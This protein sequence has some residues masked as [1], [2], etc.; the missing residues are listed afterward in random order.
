MGRLQRKCPFCRKPLVSTDEE[1]IELM[2]KRIEAND[3]V[4]MCYIGTKKYH[5]GDY[6]AAFEYWTKAVA[7]GDVRAHFELSCLYREGLGVEE[8][9]KRNCII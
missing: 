2:I 9:E 8:D 7:L 3:P 1:A 4:A 5:E 6:T